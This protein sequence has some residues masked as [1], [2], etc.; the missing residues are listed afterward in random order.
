MEYAVELRAGLMSLQ[1]KAL[2]ADPR[3]GL[4]RIG[5]DEHGLI[6][7]QWAERGTEGL[8]EPEM[9]VIV[10]PGEATFES[11]SDL[12]CHNICHLYIS[13]LQ[14]TLHLH[15]S[16]ISAHPLTIYASADSSSNLKGVYSQV[17]CGVNPQRLFLV[18][19]TI[20]QHDYHST[21]QELQPSRG[22]KV[23]LTLI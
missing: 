9:D 22:H 23:T 17:P 6:H 1:G 4:I 3:K 11:V 20:F 10:F 13:E 2:H 19:K 8:L 16:H 21:T 18:N 12:C 14:P 15:K 7:F 5:Q